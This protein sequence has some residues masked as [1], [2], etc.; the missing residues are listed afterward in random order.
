MKIKLDFIDM[1]EEILEDHEIPDERIWESQ[2]EYIKR[3]RLELLDETILHFSKNPRAFTDTGGCSYKH[4]INGGCAIGRKLPQK[5]SEEIEE[6]SIEVMDVW[7]Q[8]PVYL[9]FLGQEFLVELQ[10]LHDG[11]FWNTENSK[12]YG[13]L[14]KA[15]ELKVEKMKQLYC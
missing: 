8:I 14:S 5:L 2:D 4:S 7:D 1:A 6:N 3:K 12:N 9:K 11:N 10:K 13:P 15:G